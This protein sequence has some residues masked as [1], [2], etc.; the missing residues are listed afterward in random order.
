MS[1]SVKLSDGSYIDASGIYDY[2]QKQT[3][4]AVN[5]A[6]AQLRTEMNLIPVSG[7]GRTGGFW[8]NRCNDN[9]GNGARIGFAGSSDGYPSLYF[10]NYQGAFRIVIKSTTTGENTTWY[11][12][13]QDGLYINSVKKLSV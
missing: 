10:D 13:K 12:L 3:Q 5:A 8:L 1:Q 2:I 6:V 7:T 9:D 11:A 4:E